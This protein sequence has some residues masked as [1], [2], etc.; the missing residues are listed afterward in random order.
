M[1]AMP[2]NTIHHPPYVF[3]Q[4]FM[5]PSLLLLVG[6][7]TS[8][9]RRYISNISGPLSLSL[10]LSLVTSCCTLVAGDTDDFLIVIIGDTKYNEQGR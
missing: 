9:K 5:P 4:Y 1:G 8:S 3:I 6:D 2:P 10:S 7:K